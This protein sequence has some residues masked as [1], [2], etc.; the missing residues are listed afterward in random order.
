M[1]IRD[2]GYF[3]QKVLNC[4]DSKE[5]CYVSR[6]KP[7]LTLYDLDGKQI[8]MKE[9]A[10]KMK[11]KRL[12]QMEMWVTTNEIKK[13]IRLLVELMPDE[14]INNRLAKAEKEARKKGRQL[15]AKY[16]AYAALNLFITNADKEILSTEQLRKL[17]HLRWQIELRFKAWK[18][19][20]QLHKV[21]KMNK[22]RL[23]AIYMSS[24]YISSSIGKWLAIF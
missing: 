1:I 16:K 21:K 11:K 24:Y 14:I 7:K 23:N 19:F 2:M 15:S 22:Y 6:A 20:C 18:S 3:D 13:P 10:Q 4:I 5:A 12:Q 8:D 9:L 17:Y